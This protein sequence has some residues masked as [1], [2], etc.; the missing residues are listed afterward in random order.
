MNWTKHYELLIEK[1]KNRDL[2]GYTELH[3]IIPKCMGGSNKKDNL[4]RLTAR[5]HFIAH[6]L[7]TKIYPDKSY[8]IRAVQ[9]MC[10]QYK[11]QERS[12]NRMYGWLREKFSKEISINQTGEK[13]SQFGTCW[14]YNKDLKK[15]KKIKKDELNIWLNKGWTKGRKLVFKECKFCHKK[16]KDL[17][18]IKFC[19][20]KCKQYFRAPHLKIID[21]NYKEMKQLFLKNKSIYKTLSYF[22]DDYKKND[23]RGNKYLSQKLKNDNIII[24]SRG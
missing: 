15:S 13:N 24:L 2:Q 21:D 1:A 10:V 18:N 17:S 16:I 9:M 22:I 14:I 4:V 5:E 20:D 3:H 7:L 6:L 23:R 12:M 19:S 8:L 11:N